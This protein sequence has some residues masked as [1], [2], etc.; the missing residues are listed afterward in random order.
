VGA[1]TGRVYRVAGG[2][3]LYISNWE[4]FGGPQPTV[5]INQWSIDHQAL[6]HLREFPADG[7]FLQGL[8]SHAF[9]RITSGCRI[10]TSPEADAVDVNDYTIQTLPLCA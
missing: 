10:E 6:G 3:P 2:A 4:P 5:A 7:T 9:W 8:P 1:E